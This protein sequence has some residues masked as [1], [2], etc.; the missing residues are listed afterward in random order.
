VGD[1]RLTGRRVLIAAGA[2]PAPQTFPGAERL[3]TSDDFMNH[4]RIVEQ[5]APEKIFTGADNPRVREFVVSISG[6]H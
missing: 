4:D 5:G 1:D 6:H 2:V 3:A